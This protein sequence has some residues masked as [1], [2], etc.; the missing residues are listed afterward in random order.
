[1]PRA[2]WRGFLRLSLVACPVSLTSATLRT[3]PVRLHQVWVPGSPAPAPW[4][5][6][7]AEEPSR[8]PPR[9]GGREPPELPDEEPGAMAP[10]G[11]IAL[12]P[13][14]PETGA[15]LDAGEVVKGYEYERGR[16]VTLTDKELKALDVESSDVIDLATF[17]PRA[18]IDPLYF[19]V[20]YYVQPAGA[21]AAEAYRVIGA[22]MAE[23]GMAGLGRLTLARRERMVL[24]EPRGTG[25]LLMTLRAAEEVRAAPSVT[26]P[27]G[28]TDD[29]MVEI[30]A[31]IIQRRAGHFD[32][33]SFRDRY[34]DA[35]RDLIEAK[36]RG[37]PVKR[38]PAA[39]K[40][41]ALDLMAALKR[42][43]AQDSAPGERRRR[44]GPADRRQRAL[45][46]P[47]SG[48]GRARQSSRTATARRRKA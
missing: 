43:L 30:A 16:F 18:E 47:V 8:A 26:V 14:D 15:E 44:K 11:R 9:R 40:R 38:R 29:E 5:P 48:S 4:E 22:A 13:H 28:E 35:L 37:V 46:L 42:S 23:S 20:P 3:K 39:P 6:N 31:M 7:E 36:M 21:A 1:M 33:S 19:N 25:L 2:S 34:Q 10:A 24:V 27:D 12:R 17:V 41:P 45:L 32:P